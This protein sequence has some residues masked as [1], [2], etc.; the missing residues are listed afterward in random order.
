M[1]CPLA[2][3]WISRSL[4]GELG[5][6]REAKLKAHLEACP[7]CRALARDLEVIVREAGKLSVLEPSPA[8]W[9]KVA[10]AVRGSCEGDS[11]SFPEKKSWPGVFWNRY[12]W[13]FAAAAAL[14]LVIVGTV[15]IRQ[16]PRVAADPVREG[17]VEYTLAKLQ[18]AQDYYEKAI[19]SLNEAVQSQDSNLSPQVAE[20]FRRSLAAMDETIQACRQIVEEDPGNLTARA[21]LLTAY[22]EQVNV[23]EEMM[24]LKRSSA[25]GR[26]ETAL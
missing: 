18:E 15:I 4:D 20:I 2:Q 24:G 16:Q 5:P 10:A 11:V 22:R 25:R 7:D 21:Y 8:V 26:A 13:R 19:R 6:E 14:V 1:K 3:E 23:L 17:S 12:A 9:P